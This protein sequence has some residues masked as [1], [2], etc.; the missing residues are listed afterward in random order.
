MA[1]ISCPECGEKVSDTSKKCVHCGCEFKICNECKHVW[2]G[3][4]NVC[5]E[6]GFEIKEK[7]NSSNTNKNLSDAKEMYAAWRDGSFVR[8]LFGNYM[9]SIGL[10]VISF[11]FFVVGIVKLFTWGEGLEDI[12]TY[13]D[14]I[15]SIN[16]LIIFWAIFYV[17]SK[18]YSWTYESV[19]YNSI[20]TWMKYRKIDGKEAIRQTL[21]IDFNSMPLE[22]TL[23]YSN[24]IQVFIA[25]EARKN[26]E[27]LKNK[28]KNSAMIVTCLSFFFSLF[29][30]IFVLSNVKE[31]IGIKVFEYATKFKFSSVVSWWALIVSVVLFI[32]KF[33]YCKECEKKQKVTYDEWVKKEFPEQNDKIEYIM[34]ATDRYVE[35]ITEK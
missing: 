16:T 20:A 10:L 19:M 33:L 4:S 26:N 30:C 9:V 6:C 1:I 29:L 23:S 21:N 18:I 25:V 2:V 15:S 11:V 24:A 35:K 17:S 8:K 7:S 3:D 32:I 12:L 14:T 22:E 28:Q 13:E 31:Y 5:A 27:I 34:S